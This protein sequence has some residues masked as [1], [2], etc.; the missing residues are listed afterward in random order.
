MFLPPLRLGGGNMSW[1]IEYYLSIGDLLQLMQYYVSKELFLVFCFI[2]IIETS[3]IYCR[4]I[5]ANC[6]PWTHYR[7]YVIY[8]VFAVVISIATAPFAI[9]LAFISYYVRI[10]PFLPTVVGLSVEF[11]QRILTCLVRDIRQFVIQL[12]MNPEIRT[13]RRI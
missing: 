10:V 11:A 9:P 12:T 4:T 5:K 8:C 2:T 7:R 13:I 3:I 1:L 6:L